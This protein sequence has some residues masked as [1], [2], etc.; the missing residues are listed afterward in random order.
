MYVHAIFTASPYTQHTV[1]TLAVLPNNYLVTVVLLVV[2][3]AMSVDKLSEVRSAD[4]ESAVENE[5]MEK[6]RKEKQQYIND[7]QN[8]SH[9][10]RRTI[11][12][13]MKFN[14]AENRAIKPHKINKHSLKLSLHGVDLTSSSSNRSTPTRSPTSRATSR[15][16]SGSPVKKKVSVKLRNPLRLMKQRSGFFDQ[17]KLRRVET[18]SGDSSA[19]NTLPRRHPSIEKPHKNVLK[20][21]SL[22]SK[23]PESDPEVPFSPISYTRTQSSP[24]DSPLC[25]VVCVRI[26]TY[27]CSRA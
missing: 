7:L 2:F 8:D 14:S 6:Q 21:L 16:P 25:P 1:H 20:K 9:L 23:I 17:Q 19:A 13:A 15:S 5:K 18:D 24:A 4:E 11:R 10:K 22:D 26:C 12:M 3:L 27:A